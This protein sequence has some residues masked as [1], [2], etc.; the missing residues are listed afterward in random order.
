MQLLS[1]WSLAWHGLLA[2]LLLLY[3]LKRRRQRRVVGSTLLW[4]AALR[5]LR[6][7]RP[8][9]RL[10]PHLILLLQALAIVAGA[11]ALARP[12]LGRHPPRGAQVAVVLDTSVSMA[13]RGAE[14]RSRLDRARRVA[15]QTVKGIG[16]GGRF[17]LVEASREP[18]VLLSGA[19]DATSATEVLE[20]VRVRAGG[21]DLEGAVAVASERLRGASAGSRIVVLT[22]AA[23]PGELG[24]EAS[25]PVQVRRI[26]GPRDNTGIVALDVRSSG[27]PDAPDRTEVFV[28][29]A[30]HADA[31]KDVFVTASSPGRGTLASRRVQ[32]P[33]EGTESI[34][35]SAS[36]APDPTDRPSFVRV[37]LAEPLGRGRRAKLDDALDV[38]DVA[39]APAP[40]VRKLS[41]LLIG[42]ALPSLER[43][44]RTDA[45]VDLFSTTLEKLRERAADAPPL[46]GLRVYIGPTPDEPPAGDSVVIAPEGKRAF[47]VRLGEPIQLPRIV[48]WRREDPRMRFVNMGEVHLGRARPMREGAGRPLVTTE[49]GPVI[50][51]VERP[52]GES[53]IVSFDPARSDWPRHPSYVIFFRNLVERARARKAEGGIAPGGLGEPLR[54]PAPNA[55][56]VVVHTP[57]GQRIEARAPGDMVAVPVPPEPG[58]YRV[59]VGSR[60][61]HALRSLLEAP[62]TNLRP[63]LQL[64]ESAA[65]STAP[66][67]ATP[68]PPREAWP[69]L[70]ATLLILGTVVPVF[71][72]RS[73]K[74]P[75]RRNH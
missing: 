68:G 65:S 51:T 46:E 45:N 35:M 44:F 56:Q 23:Q 59:E 43:V 14:G 32:L 2:P 31:P 28:R 10:V 60:T 20:Q 29:M 18:S 19:D 9:R 6:A 57:E 73:A 39:F 41:V 64:T 13:A 26:G 70:A 42:R 4:E 74:A 49:A 40:G 75:T 30:R 36:I 34:A 17:T 50:A 24:L 48:T 66:T 55:Q 67:D 61:L 3:V 53:T 7:E 54:V 11:L 16:P 33:A 38:D 47:E 58:I 37:E 63:R 52:D 5:D 69:Y 71:Q 25:V 22:D 21:A 62:E 15:E 12:T 72:F 8:W 1:P 27:D